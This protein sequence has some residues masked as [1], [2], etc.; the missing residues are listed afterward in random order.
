MRGKLGVMG[1]LLTVFWLPISILVTAL[2]IGSIINHLFP[3]SVV[4]I[5]PFADALTLYSGMVQQIA[6]PL[7]DAANHYV[8]FAIPAWA[9]DAVVAYAASASGFAMGGTNFTSP[10]EQFHTVKSSAASLGWPLA[11]LTFIFNAV[12]NRHLSKFASQ[13]TFLFVLYVA[14]VGA[15]LA[16]AVWGPQLLSQGA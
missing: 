13:H 2:A 3:G 4:W 5:T 12:R 8:G 16:G 14:A 10:D 15:V 1:K 7:S 11:I 6:N 9:P